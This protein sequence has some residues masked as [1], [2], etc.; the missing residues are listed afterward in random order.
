MGSTRD[1]QAEGAA[2]PALPD[3]QE[4]C[5][6]SL[7]HPLLRN[8]AHGICHRAKNDM[9][10]L[11]ALVGMAA[12]HVEHP[13]DLVGALEGRVG[14]ISVAYSLICETGAP[15]CLDH[16]IKTVA[17]RILAMQTIPVRP[18]YRLDSTALSMRLCSA[19][20]LWVYEMVTN[21][22]THGIPGPGQPH[23]IIAGGKDDAGLSLSIRDFGPGL[24]SWFNPDRDEK[25]GMKLARALALHDLRGEMEIV[26]TQPGLE[27][28][29][30]VPNDEFNSLNREMFT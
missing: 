4:D 29:L 14:A 21:A 10:T 30:F 8:L 17:N 25:M 11:S 12:V 7:E 18:D 26:S 9:Q 6:V 2:A 19:L 24:A 16:V 3:E 28:R 1:L 13:R 20:A 5:T 27:A 23:M 22:Q 15:P